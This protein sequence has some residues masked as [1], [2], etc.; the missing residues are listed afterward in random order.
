MSSFMSR[1]ERTALQ[2]FRKRTLTSSESMSRFSPHDKTQRPPRF[3]S[4]SRA[5]HD[6]CESA[7]NAQRAS[8]GCVPSYQ[9]HSAELSSRTVPC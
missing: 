4:P 5:W 7:L 8:C 3:A 9:T 1:A 6:A 2:T